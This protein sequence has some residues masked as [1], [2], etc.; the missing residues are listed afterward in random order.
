MRDQVKAHVR[1]AILEHL[2]EYLEDMSDPATGDHLNAQG[3]AIV[4]GARDKYTASGRGTLP[5][6]LGQLIDVFLRP[7][8]VSWKELFRALIMNALK[9]VPM[10]GYKRVS[11]LRAAIA[12]Q[13]KRKGYTLA[14]RIPLFPG[15]ELDDKFTII[16]VMDTSGSMGYD[17]LAAGFAEIQ[18]IQK[19]A[20]ELEIYVLHVD[21]AVAKAQKMGPY[22]VLDSEAAGR[23]GTDFETAFAYI[24]ENYQHVDLVVYATDGYAPAPTTQLA[25]PT[26]WLLT[27]SGHD[28]IGTRAGHYVLRM[29]DYPA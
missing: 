22:D 17:D 7:P 23:G 18:H 14:R 8:T 2:F 6:Y 11:K 5:S 10:F 21:A 15:T 28:P 20:N 13:F 19:S 24:K 9:V 1:N 27:P 29:Q 16:Y 4:R 12:R 25:C 26:V 3:R